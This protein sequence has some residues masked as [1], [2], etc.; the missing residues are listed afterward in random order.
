MNTF[1]IIFDVYYVLFV[2]NKLL[3]EGDKFVKYGKIDITEGDT[4]LLSVEFDSG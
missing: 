1:I 2:R 3:F 4:G